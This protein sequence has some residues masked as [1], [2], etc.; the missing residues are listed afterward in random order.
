MPFTV[1]PGLSATD[2]DV[3]VAGLGVVAATVDVATTPSGLLVV[4]R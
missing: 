4:V 3:G 1:F 2:T